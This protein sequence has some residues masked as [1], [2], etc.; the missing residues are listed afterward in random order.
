[1]NVKVIP[2]LCLML[3]LG[4]IGSSAFGLTYDIQITDG[5]NDAEEHLDDGDM[6]VTSSDLEFP[7]E[8]N[9]DPS[10]S[11]AQLLVLRFAS[12]PI[13][14]GARIISAYLEFEVDET[15]G[16]DKPVNVIVEG[17]L[18]PD[19]PAI[20][21]AARDLSSREPWTEAKVKWT[22]PMD[23]VTNDKF[24]SPDLTAVITELISQEGW[25]S[26]NALALA[27]R[28]D[29]DNPSTG[30][31]CV[32]AVDGEAAG[33]PLLRIEVFVPEATSPD[34][35]DG[36]GDVTSPLL[37]WAPGDG[38]MFHQ[39]YL[40]TQPEL[41][42]ADMA[43]PPTPAPLYFHAP[44]LTPG[45]TYYWRVDETAAD[46]TVAVGE[47]W[48]FT[49]MPVAAYDPSPAD[50]AV[51]QRN[52]TTVS[53]TAGS[54]AMSHTVYGGTDKA[55]V[56][57][58]DPAFL[59]AEQAETSLVLGDL[60]PMTVFYWK[61]DEVDGA[62]A[63]VPGPVWTIEVAGKNT[64]SW[65]TAA[66]TI[67]PGYV[68]TYVA[69]GLYD[70]GAFSE[71]ITYEFVVRSN[72]DEEQASMA[73]IGRR[74]FGDTQVGLKY[75]QWNNTGTYGATVFGVLDYDYGVATSPG[76]YTHLA[77]VSSEAAGATDL[78]VNGVLQGSV[79]TAITLSGPVGIGYGAQGEDG[80]G[81]F[82][83]F[84]GSI[85]G[86][87]IYDRAL[88]EAEIAANAEAFLVGGPEAVTLD[89]QILDGGDDAE[90]HL[91][92]NRMDI[93]SSDLE[94]P[95][96]DNGDPASDEQL[97]VLRFPSVLIPKGAEVT[98]AYLEFEV[99]ESKGNDKVVNVVVEGQLTPDA[100]AIANVAG[101]LSG[102]A[103]WTVA[104]VKWTVPMDLSTNDT[105]Q[106]PDLTAVLAEIVSQEG[107]AS[108]NA[109]ALVV[110]DDKDNPSTGLRC[111]EAAD[112]EAKAAPRLHIEILIP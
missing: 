89:L 3:M 61:V 40:G 77:F 8:D 41:G 87:A 34:P 102:R 10:A 21:G 80:S 74:Q 98:A 59:L 39:V 9:G 72:P 28:D 36:A 110:R 15:K 23:L 109:L 69:D 11:D 65:R 76:E 6:D 108:G 32:E 55:A 90:E 24:Q 100:P 83:D 70:I 50:G 106:S 82:D 58:G 62:G 73:L 99:D 85:F 27:V 103:P 51:W 44:G 42:D 97:L 75:E 54:G 78:Y 13:A 63:V 35:A 46:G 43:G 1:M 4:F 67:E 17:Q 45:V 94:F 81:A 26:G 86:V 30:L 71:D 18:T 92:D 107:W 88:T 96:E 101:D 12:V 64:G 56:A 48:S 31:R 57:A 38:A 5:S 19:A 84:D 79:A 91:D 95:Y 2:L 104:N 53:W 105:F 16:N 93:G 112:G 52:D 25:A 68:A 20:S 29:P 14:N 49:A 22:V 33:A 7:Y 66:E 47:V 111:V 60:E 37:Q